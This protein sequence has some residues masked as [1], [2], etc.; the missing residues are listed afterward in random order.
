MNTKVNLFK[1][2]RTSTGVRCCPVVEAANGRVRPHIVIVD[3]KE[4]RHEEGAYYISW[5]EGRTV[6]RLS[7]GN[8]PAEAWSRRKKKQ[9][10]LNAIANGVAV[11]TEST[12]GHRLLSGEIA[13]YLGEVKLSSKP[14]TLLSYTLG[15]RY[16]AESCDKRFV[17]D[18]TRVD[19]LKFAAFLRDVKKLSARTSWNK[20]GN[21]VSFL[22]SRDVKLKLKRG[23]WPSYT[24]E[25]PEV[26]ERE[27]LDALFAACDTGE[28][29]WFEFFLMTGMREQEVQHAYWRDVNFGAATV[30]VTHKPDRGWTPKAYKEREIPIP[31]RLLASLKAWKAR[32]DGRCELIFHTKTCHIKHDFLS[33]LKAIAERGGLDPDDCWL[34]K[35]RA[36]FATWHLWTGVDLRT[37]QEWLGHSEMDSTMRYLKPSR[38]QKARQKVNETFAE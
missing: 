35:F 16:F 31:A 33:V 23:D 10:E 3:D 9:A 29:L 6:K 1:R 4:E 14:R 15:L 20:F 27:D 5:Y 37:V 32:S 8:D 13:A 28:R 25:E 34:H 2:V 22:K 38:D 26:Y 18:I 12:N 30:S 7:V 17:D 36:T 19:M 11:V 24:L 21:A